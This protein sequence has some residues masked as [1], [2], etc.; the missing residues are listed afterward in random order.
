MP[1][2]HLRIHQPPAR[3]VHRLLQGL[4]VTLREALLRGGG[5]MWLGVGAQREGGRG[6]L[7][8]MGRHACTAP[9]ARPCV[10]RPASQ[11]ASQQQP[12]ALALA[13]LRSIAPPPHPLK[14]LTSHL[15]GWQLP[16]RNA[17]RRHQRH[18]GVC[19][20]MH[21]FANQ[22]Q[23]TG[24]LPPRQPPPPTHTPLLRPTGSFARPAASCASATATAPAATSSSSSGSRARTGVCLVTAEWM[25]SAVA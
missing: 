19:Q 15:Q 6:C 18:C 13:A 3:V 1:P 14:P 12:L 16:T 24:Y 23:L 25:R 10:L 4:Q 8:G 7:G 17:G 2:A 20:C 9:V 22:R 21:G 11:P 5:G